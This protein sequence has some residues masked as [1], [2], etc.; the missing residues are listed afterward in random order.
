MTDI[1]TVFLDIDDTLWWFSRN[2]IVALRHVYDKFDIARW[3]SDYESFRSIYVAKNRE[4]WIQYHYGKIA[5]DYL[6]N[7][8]F[9]YTLREIGCDVDIDALARAMNVEYLSFLSTLKEIVPGSKQLLE[10]LNE[11]G[12]DVNVLSN[13]FPRVQTGKLRSGGLDGYIHHMVLSDDC[14]VTKPLR[15][16]FDYALEVCGADVDSTVMIGDNADAD[17]RG[18]HEA[19]W[20][21]IYFNINNVDIDDALADVTV[22]SLLEIKNI[23]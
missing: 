1:K 17:I 13:G 6:L 14:G 21:T 7:E 11:R 2:S 12:Y 4:L 9:R 15:G 23:L 16:I 5:T 18:A 22:N 3:S 20:K 19:G 10:Y 8:R